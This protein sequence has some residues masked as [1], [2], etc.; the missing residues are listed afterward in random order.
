MG[1]DMFKIDED[2]AIP[3]NIRDLR[4]ALGPGNYH[5]IARNAGMTPQHVSRILRRRHG[6]SL[7]IAAKVA[8]AAG[9]T[10]DDL[11]TYTTVVNEIFGKSV[12]EMIYE[13]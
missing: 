5:A 10:L 6:T 13:R 2:R 11:Y 9:V 4:N 1:T 3:P 7:E 12:H 8:K